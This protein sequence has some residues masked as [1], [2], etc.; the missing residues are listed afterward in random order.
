MK[1][2]C[3]MNRNEDLISLMEMWSLMLL[4]LEFFLNL[5]WLVELYQPQDVFVFHDTLN[6]LPLFNLICEDNETLW[7]CIDCEQMAWFIFYN[8][9]KYDELLPSSFFPKKVQI[10]SAR[11]SGVSSS[12]GRFFWSSS[13]IMLNI[14]CSQENTIYYNSVPFNIKIMTDT[15]TTTDI[16]Y[17]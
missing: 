17:A 8:S 10:L 4:F 1:V 2:W 11:F 9:P 7:K 15:L 6:E 16:G 13:G 12:S 3:Q 14:D 5:L